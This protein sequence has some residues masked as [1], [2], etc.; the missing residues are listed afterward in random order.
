MTPPC[1]RAKV[2]NQRQ[3]CLQGKIRDIWR[4]F[5][6]PVWIG[7]EIG[8]DTGVWRVETSNA[9]KYL[10]MPRQPHNKDYLA[11]NVLVLKVRKFTAKKNKVLVRKGKKEGSS[12]IGSSCVYR[13]RKRRK[14]RNEVADSNQTSLLFAQSMST[15][16]I[17]YL[18]QRKPSLKL[19]KHFSSSISSH[20]MW[21]C[22]SP[23]ISCWTRGFM[24]MI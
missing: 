1:C 21:N 18:R 19:M 14:G 10:A 6:G 3:F 22:L 8:G 5:W 7:R 23:L 20:D 2:C 16:G 24:L 17:L 12:W 13:S 11:P 9:A 15:L 4:C